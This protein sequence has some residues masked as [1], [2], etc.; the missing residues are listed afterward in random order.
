MKK[1]KLQ[2]NCLHL[3]KQFGINDQFD[4]DAY[5]HTLARV[6][7]NK[8]PKNSNLDDFEN[9]LNNGLIIDRSGN[10]YINL[11]EFVSRPFYPDSIFN[12]SAMSN[13]IKTGF[14]LLNNLHRGKSTSPMFSIDGLADTLWMLGLQYD[15]VKG[16]KRAELILKSLRNDLLDNSIRLSV[17]MGENKNFNR[18]AYL[19]SKW[20]LS[21]PGDI[22]KDILNH[23]LRLNQ[24]LWLHNNP[25]IAL[26][27]FNGASSEAIPAFK[28]NYKWPV[29]GTDGFMKKDVSITNA[30]LIKY[31]EVVPNSNISNPYL[32]VSKVSLKDITKMRSSISR[33]IDGEISKVDQRVVRFADKSPKPKVTNKFSFGNLFRLQTAVL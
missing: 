30:A 10:G 28:M 18:T 13:L 23:G 27:F 31:R 16:R 6:A 3:L 5:K 24:H 20:G 12:Y 26:T 22:R 15:C 17:E 8:D 33:F 21:L 2:A 29:K 9:T 4:L 25:S 1:N 7:F 11:S 32:D 19:D 14:R